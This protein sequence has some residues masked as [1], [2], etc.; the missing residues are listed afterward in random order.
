MRILFQWLG[1]VIFTFWMFASVAVWSVV[2]VI[3]APLPHRFRFSIAQ[4]WIRMIMASLRILCGLDYRVIGRE[5]IPD[6]A[7][8]YLLKHSSAFETL[9]ELII[10]PRQTWVLKREL[11]WIPIFGW[12]LSQLKPIAINRSGGRNAVKQV[13]ALGQERLDEGIN[14]MIFPEGTRVRHGDTRRY[15]VSGAALAAASGRRIVPVA[16]N[17]GAFWPRRGIMKH[18]GTVTFVVG[19]PIEVGDRDLKVV[20]AEIQAWVEAEIV[21]MGGRSAEAAARAASVS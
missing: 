2:L 6:E 10:F 4:A 20:N 17:A 3:A 1:S 18:P 7:S 8:V 12:A 19:E 13:I 9:A 15:G 11:K 16:H 14:V 21:M 5:N